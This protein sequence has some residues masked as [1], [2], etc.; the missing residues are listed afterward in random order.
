[1]IHIIQS[2]EYNNSFLKC[3]SCVKTFTCFILLDCDYCQ[4]IYPWIILL[5]LG[6]TFNVNIEYC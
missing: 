5:E 3:K 2:V 1:M 4:H 6:K